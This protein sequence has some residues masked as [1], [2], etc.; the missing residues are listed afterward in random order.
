MKEDLVYVALFSSA[1]IGAIFIKFGLA[2]TTSITGPVMF[3]SPLAY[4]IPLLPFWQINPTNDSQ[5]PTFE[6][7]LPIS[8]LSFSSIITDSSLS[9]RLFC[10][11]FFKH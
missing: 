3:N 11:I 5:Q 4:H 8:F 7:F 6:A 10:I 1:D 2:P 9:A